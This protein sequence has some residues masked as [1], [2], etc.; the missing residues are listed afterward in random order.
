VVAIG[1]EWKKFKEKIVHL[2]SKMKKNLKPKRTRMVEGDTLKVKRGLLIIALLAMF[3]L[4]SVFWPTANAWTTWSKLGQY[5]TFTMS[6]PTDVKIGENMAID[7]T[8]TSIYNFITISPRNYFISIE[9]L[10]ISFYGANV[11]YYKTWKNVTLRYLEEIH[12]NA[13]L[14]PTTEGLVL[15]TIRTI[16]NYTYEGSST[17]GSSS[18]SST[19]YVTIVRTATYNELLN[20]QNLLYNLMYFFV[21]TTITFTATTVYLAKRKPKNN[22]LKQPTQKQILHDAKHAP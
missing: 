10:S 8:F 20:R 19:F 15:C 7:M 17:V 11:S 9:T 5:L 2:Q 6:S 1:E 22:K 12:D 4:S 16:Y 3:F 13:T 18:G 21:L 14:K